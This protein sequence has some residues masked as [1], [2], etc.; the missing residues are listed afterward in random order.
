MKSQNPFTIIG[1][2][3]AYDGVKN[4]PKRRGLDELLGKVPVK[5]V[6][7]PKIGVVKTA[8]LPG[9]DELD[10]KSK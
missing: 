7:V 4:E 10:T 6:C 8:P 5:I 2:S 1:E 3:K 9:A